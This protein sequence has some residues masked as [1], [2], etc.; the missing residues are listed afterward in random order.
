MHSGYCFLNLIFSGFVY[1]CDKDSLIL[2]SVAILD[3]AF[4]SSSFVDTSYIL[5]YIFQLVLRL[6]TVYLG[7]EQYSVKI[8]NYYYI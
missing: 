6:F 8:I 5:F 2:H 7:L 1:M 4:G 3:I